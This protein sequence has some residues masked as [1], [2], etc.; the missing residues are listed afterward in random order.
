MLSGKPSKLV[1]SLFA[2]CLM[3]QANWPGRA[4]AVAQAARKFDEFGDILYSDKIARL[5]NFAIQ[6]QQEPNAR[7]FIIVYRTRRDLPGLSSRYAVWMK[8]YMAARGIEAKRVMTVDGGVASCLTQ[9][10]WIAPPGTAPTP[11][12]DAY[13]NSLVDTD[14]AIKIDEH[15]YPLP[16]DNYEE[17]GG[18]NYGSLASDLE[19]LAAALRQRPKAQA[20]IIAYAQNYVECRTV[21]NGDGRERALRRL[22]LDPPGAARKILNTEKDYLVKTY[23][24]APARIKVVDGGYRSLRQVELWLVPPGASAPVPTPN[25][26]PR[27]GKR[28]GR[29]S[30]AQK[31]LDDALTVRMFGVE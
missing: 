15:Y 7:G 23:R 21:D 2:V 17:V 30:Q 8:N 11:R 16:Q 9:E 26:F 28:L 5:D 6:L 14:T 20:Y 22:H 19:A 12:S 27:R 1:V 31:I 13:D 24:L 4:Q 18:D 10:L 3:F 29:R 25:Q